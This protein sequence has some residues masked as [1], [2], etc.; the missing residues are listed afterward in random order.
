[1]SKPHFT[2]VLASKRRGALFVG[3]TDDLVNR[4]LDHKCNL[5]CG[6]TSQYA[7]HLL[8]YYERHPD[9]GTALQG[10]RHFREMHRLW[11]LE[12]IER[13]NPHWCDLYEDLT[14]SEVQ[15][16]VPG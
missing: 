2:Y 8:V 1:M 7:I 13:C 6:I 15:C 9:R 4:V 12:L 10:E 3:V 5:V 16:L 14:S 11:K